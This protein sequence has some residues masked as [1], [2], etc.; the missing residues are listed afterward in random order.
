MIKVKLMGGLGNQMFQFSFGYAM[1]QKYDTSFLIDES[2]LIKLPTATFK[3]VKREFDLEIFEIQNAS[4][5]YEGVICDKSNFFY[6]NFN[7][8]LPIHLRRYYV[9]RFFHFDNKLENINFNN[10]T[11]EGYWQSYRYFEKYEAEIKNIF[12]HKY[13][14]IPQSESLLNEIISST[15]VCINVR[16]GDFTSNSYHGVQEI[17]YY[18]NAVNFI[19]AK[20]MVDTFY[21]FS[22]DIEWC[23][24]NFNFINNKVIV[25]HTHKGHKFGNYF[26][27]MRNCKHFVIPNSSFAWWSAW[28]ALNQEKIVICPLKWFTNP[29]INTSDLIPQKWIRI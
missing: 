29:Q 20:I 12:K 1:A 3:G 17:E 7:K 24:N 15:S 28:L 22:D 9:E 5:C 16:R 25:D 27:L 4:Y 8:L 11:F 14:V 26:E 6:R 21:I 10:I 23:R 18:V 19:T 13:N 2:E